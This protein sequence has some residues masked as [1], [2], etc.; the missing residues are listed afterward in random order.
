MVLLQANRDERATAYI[1]HR[2]K[3]EWIFSG[4][5][6][7][8]FGTRDMGFTRSPRLMNRAQAHRYLRNWYPQATIIHVDDRHKVITYSVSK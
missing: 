4:V 1:I 6:R 2:K 5:D 8:T 3:T 7:G